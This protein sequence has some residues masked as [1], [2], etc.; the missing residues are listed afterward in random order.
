MNNR[1]RQAIF[2]ATMRSKGFV[3]ATEWVPS[4]HREQ[5]RDV[6]R[7]LRDGTGSDLAS[8]TGKAAQGK[9]EADARIAELNA[10]NDALAYKVDRLTRDLK[11]RDN[12]NT[13]LGKRLDELVND[14]AFL[15][16][17]VATWKTEGGTETTTEPVRPKSRRKKV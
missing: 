8:V 16:S 12:E 14:L 9:P 13:R 2:K 11:A 15:R 5:F 6:A 1:E 10:E 4:E 17:R 3:A 7:A